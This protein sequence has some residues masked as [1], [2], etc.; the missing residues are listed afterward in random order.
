M[1]S[2]QLYRQLLIGSFLSIL[3]VLA[4]TRLSQNLPTEEFSQNIRTTEARSPEEEKAGFRLPPGFEIQLF[5]SEPDIGKP[6]NMAFDAKG[7]MWLTQSYEYPFA[8]TS[9]KAKD[10]ISILE[11]ADGDGKAEKITVFAEG[12]NI[13]IGIVPV[14]D[15]A[16]AYSI[17]SIDHYIDRDGDDKVD[18]RK[19]L[20]KGFE[21]KDT[22]GMVNNLIRSW[23]GWIHA[24][25]GF[26]NTSTVAGSDGDTIVLN[27]GNTFRF[28]AD[29]S[30]LEFTTTG[31]VNPYGYAYDEM[32]YTYSSDCHTSPIYQLVRGADYPHFAKKPTGIGFGPALMDHN[33]G[34]T[35]L[36]GLDYYL[37]TQY[38]ED[39][40]NSFFIGDVVKSRVYRSTMTMEGTTPKIRWEDDF[41]VSEDPWFRPVDVKLG[42]DGAIYIADFY[43]RIIGHYEVPLDHPGR[44]RQR[45]R[46]WRIV[47]KGAKGSDQMTDWTKADMRQ[48]IQGLD[49]PNLPLR[50]RVADQIVDKYGAEAAE[51]I[52]AMLASAETSAHQ[53]VQ[54]LWI[55]FRLESLSTA[56]LRAA[57]QSEDLLKTIHALRILFEMQEVDASLLELVVHA[58]QHSSP[59]IQRQATMVLSQH[60]SPDHLSILLALRDRV[61]EEDSHFF[62]ST[63]QAIRDQLRSPTLLTWVLEQS[64]EEQEAKTLAALMLGVNSQQAA[65]YLTEH[66]H[67]FEGSVKRTREFVRHIG[68]YTDASTLDR[69]LSILE[70]RSEKSPQDALGYLEQLMEGLTEAGRSISPKGKAL[71]TDLTTEVL[72]TS[73]ANTQ[74]WY[75]IPH[76]HY[77]SQRNPWRIW[78]YSEPDVPGPI[79]VIASGPRNGV[80][81]FISSIQSPPFQLPSKLSFFLTGGQNEPSIN[82]TPAP[83][84]SWVELRLASTDSLIVRTLAT[85]QHMNQT[86]SWSLKTYEGQLAY[87]QLVDGSGAWGDVVALGEIDPALVE[88]PTSGPDE[89]SDQLQFA[90]R[91]AE[92]YKLTALQAAMQQLLANGRADIFARE[93]AAAMLLK[94][95]ESQTITLVQEVVSKE[96]EPLLLKER[97]SVLL[98]SKGI[99]SSAVNELPYRTQKEMAENLAANSEGVALLLAAAEQGMF[100][101]RL[102]LEPSLQERLEASATS[103][104]QEQLNAFTDGVLLP[105]EKIESLISDRA[106]GFRMQR[107]SIENGRSVFTQHCTA[108]HQIDGQGGQIGPQLDGIGNWGIGALSEKIL[109]PNRNISKAFKTYLLRL[110]DGQSKSGLFL[111][112]EGQLRVFSDVAGQ[113]F[114]IQKEEIVEQKL[115][116]YSLMPAHFAEVIPEEDFYDLLAFLLNEQ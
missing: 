31:R 27:S 44:D 48:L 104:Q 10:K 9:G 25:H 57:L 17:P 80:G 64:W 95:D 30:H 77:P 26:A 81:S 55:L 5:A 58:I 2:S 63:R 67:R 4:C 49:H 90:C 3:L 52:S 108:C 56:Q 96:G 68:R 37:G 42:P 1:N 18:E 85:D 88:L 71:I 12:L 39:Y 43:N 19:V 106:K 45:G 84:H 69:L 13:P 36:A 21:Y 62:Y 20:Y 23:D 34:S 50:M 35:A 15:G 28:R 29:G 59:H 109:D 112:E 87:L 51:D 114:S 73:A 47:Y 40:R 70:I 94:F 14:H 75:V 16:I 105:D 38:P 6:L 91:I 98:S 32:G 61:S 103:S 60:P 76:D 65:Q 100:S 110:K 86:I 8:D 41:I 93:E 116:P 24:D 113:E 101:P 79:R 102:L 92:E 66:L 82:E 72:Q 46:I 78:D 115:S 7:R 83:P 33:Y 89:Q 22:H 53:Y 54:G 11:D 97:L 111:R 107:H 74:G 99:L